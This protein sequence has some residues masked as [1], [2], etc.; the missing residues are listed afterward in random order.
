[1]PS[2]LM[3]LPSK[4]MRYE[5]WEVLDLAEKEFEDWERNVKIENLK[6]WL[7]EARARQVE[8]GVCSKEINPTPL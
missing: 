2:A 6:G 1:M 4:L 5:G 8:K 7:I 3:K